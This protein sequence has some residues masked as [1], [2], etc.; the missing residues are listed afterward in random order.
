MI[1]KVK[2]S[3]GTTAGGTRVT[4]TGFN[5]WP[6]A[7]VDFGGVPATEVVLVE[8]GRL[9]VTAPP[10]RPGRVYVTVRNPDGREG[11]RGWAYRYVE[12]EGANPAEA[13]RR[14][15][16]RAPSPPARERGPR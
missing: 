5:L 15:A 8:R 7:A 6:D 10:H 4:I 11:S 3:S 13:S 14:G 2:P 16:D 9:E 1:W 12:A